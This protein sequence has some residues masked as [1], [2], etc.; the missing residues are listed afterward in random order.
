MSST[1]VRGRKAGADYYLIDMRST[2]GNCALFWRPHG[3]G[4]TTQLEEAGL[5]TLE[6]AA[7]HRPTDVPV[8]KDHVAKA[9]V[10]HVRLDRLRDITGVDLGIKDR[11]KR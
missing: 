10:T 9:A 8:H 4:Y 1:G 5:Y 6:E 11:S 7:S 2:V 3:N